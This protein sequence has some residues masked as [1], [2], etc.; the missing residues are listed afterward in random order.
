MCQAVSELADE[1]GMHISIGKFQTLN[2]CLDDA[3]A[4]AVTS[5]GR[6]RE[7]LINDQAETLQQRFDFFR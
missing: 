7:V 2:R 1:Q 5:F 4:E 3:M 6:A